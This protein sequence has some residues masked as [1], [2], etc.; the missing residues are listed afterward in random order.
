MSAR[1]TTSDKPSCGPGGRSVLCTG[2]CGAPDDQRNLSWE[3]PPIAGDAMTCKSCLSQVG[4]NQKLRSKE[5][6][7]YQLRGARERRKEIKIAPALEGS[8][9][10][11]IHTMDS[12]TIHPEW[13]RTPI[14][15]VRKECG[16]PLTL[17]DVVKQRI[18]QQLARG[19]S[20][21]TTSHPRVAQI[22]CAGFLLGRSKVEAGH[23]PA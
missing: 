3:M 19:L 7:T 15:G 5:S 12:P 23:S 22:T 20:R 4:P 11:H 13:R 21:I 10:N 18:K 2:T 6:W 17:G 8:G 16:D 14:G 9:A 1:G